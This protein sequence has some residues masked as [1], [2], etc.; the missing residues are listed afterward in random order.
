M[1]SWMM[2]HQRKKKLEEVMEELKGEIIDNKELDANA[3]ELYYKVSVL[4]DDVIEER[5]KGEW[6]SVYRTLLAYKLQQDGCRVR[7]EKSISSTPGGSKEY[8]MRLD[9]ELD[10]SKVIIE[11]KKGAINPKHLY[12]LLRYM[13]AT[14][15]RIGFLVVIGRSVEVV[16]VLEQIENDNKEYY[17]YDNK[18]LRKMAKKDWSEVEY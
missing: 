8:N 16:M 5:G 7:E 14:K 11:M 9:I 15:T 17:Y 13:D 2:I 18:T 4:I 6:E 1:S 10:N 3:L 12:Q